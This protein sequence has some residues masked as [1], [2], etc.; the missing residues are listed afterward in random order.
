LSEG[1]AVHL[2]RFWSGYPVATLTRRL[3]NRG[4]WPFRRLLERS[5]FFD[6]TYRRACYML[7]GSFTGFLI[8]EFGWEAYRKLY[9]KCRPHLVEW[10]FQR[11][12]G[13]SFAEAEARWRER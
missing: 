2:Q 3:G 8:E 10:A 9:R 7:A 5:F 1:L 6:R 11:E 4:E 12:L 13:I